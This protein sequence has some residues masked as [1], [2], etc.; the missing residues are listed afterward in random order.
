MKREKILCKLMI[1]NENILNLFLWRNRLK[2]L[3]YLLTCDWGFSITE[4]VCFSPSIHKF[5]FLILAQNNL[6]IL[7]IKV[8]KIIIYSA[9]L[10]IYDE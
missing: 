7:N 4:I 3:T 8:T 10:Y 1:E 6:Q 5:H 2:I 9:Y